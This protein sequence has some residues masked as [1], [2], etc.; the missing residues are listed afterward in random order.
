[1]M[2]LSLRAVALVAAIVAIDLVCVVPWRGNLA[3]R[4]ISD[5]SALA[6]TA[7]PQTAAVVARDNLDRLDGVASARRLDPSWYMLYAGNCEVLGRL[8]AAIDAYTR[9]LRIDDRPEFYENRGMI[10]LRLGRDDAAIADLAKAARFDPTVLEHL[11][12]EVRARVTAAA[13]LK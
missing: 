8:P 2:R 3:L 13:G 5:R 11:D 12:G 6:L 4:E 1:M 9:A 10:L 7:E